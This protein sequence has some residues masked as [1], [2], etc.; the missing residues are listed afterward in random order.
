MEVKF[1]HIPSVL[2]Q[3]T[4]SLSL[5]DVFKRKNST[6]LKEM[7]EFRKAVVVALLDQMCVRRVCLCEGRS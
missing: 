4:C 5:S 7:K 3:E 6:V 2:C 1:I